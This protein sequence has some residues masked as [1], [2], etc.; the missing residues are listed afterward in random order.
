MS[1][2]ALSFCA[3]LGVL[4]LFS[5]DQF[6]LKT[7]KAGNRYGL[8]LTV[9]NP[10]DL[11]GGGALARAFLVYAV[12]MTLIYVFVVM[13][14]TA[15]VLIWEGPPPTF[16]AEAVGGGALPDAAEPAPPAPGLETRLATAP[17]APPPADPQ[18]WVP[19]AI[20]LAMIG[21]GP[22]ISILQKIEEKLRRVAHRFMGVPTLLELGSEDIARAKIT[23][24]EIGEVTL[25]R[26][27]QIRSYMDAATH[28]LGEG[29]RTQRLEGLLHKIFAFRIWVVESRVW[30][31]QIVRDRY[32]VIEGEVVSVMDDL[33]GDLDDLSDRSGRDKARPAAAL[34]T[35]ARRWESRIHE[36]EA[37]CDR[38]CALMFVY[39]EKARELRGGQGAERATVFIA[40][41]LEAR[42]PARASLD[43]LLALVLGITAV[44]FFW[45]YGVASFNLLPQSSSPSTPSR[46]A[47]LYA[48]SA[49]FT[50]GP[51]MLAAMGWSAIADDDAVA[52]AQI[53]PT[54][55][56][57]FI[58][59]ISFLVALL[60]L[61]ALNIANGALD[62]G[63]AKVRQNLPQALRYAVE[64]EAPRAVLGGIQGVF[65]ALYFRMSNQ[66][67]D[68]WAP[69]RVGALHALALAVA[70]GV[71][72][73]LSLGRRASLPELFGSAPISAAI[74]AITGLL[75]V[76]MLRSASRNRKPAA[77]EV[78]T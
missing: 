30:P 22:R 76:R 67:L 3:G 31:P 64:L 75:L 24:D 51:A 9:L 7:W 61:V 1:P 59:L 11:R 38:A 45:G 43:I 20:S 29:P 4:W 72:T 23:L 68:G 36:A 46:T 65:V 26:R 35:L 71:A 19:L 2:F 27:Q 13:L 47:M 17:D 52:N 34:A 74:G 50:Y 62:A 40:H 5:W 78:T 6:N 15:G 10:A 14:V 58:F 41:A 56:M 16:T 32:Q 69:V 21:L 39:H 73:E 37:V 70:S 33:I 8:I 42:P 44:A 53:F 48:L 12:I 49:F 60:S 66:Q 77:E 63:L 25:D 57:A 18:P 28:V 54:T 55:R